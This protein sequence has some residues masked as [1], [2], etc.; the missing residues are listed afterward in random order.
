MFTQFVRIARMFIRAER[1]GNWPLHLKATQGMLPYFTAAG[2]NNYL[3]CCR[4]YLQDCSNPCTC[5]QKIF[6]DGVFTVRKNEKIFW[7][8]TWSDMT[9]E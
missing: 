5:I 1:T 9:I 2:H 8:G 4:L 6:D 7:S 3:M